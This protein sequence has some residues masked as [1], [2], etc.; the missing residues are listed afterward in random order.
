[1]IDDGDLVLCDVV[2]IGTVL[3]VVITNSNSRLLPTRTMVRIMSPMTHEGVEFAAATVTL[4]IKRFMLF[5]DAHS[6]KHH[7]DQA[8]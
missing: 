3:G 2:L 6:L 7:A 8:T 1:M 5:I 4:L